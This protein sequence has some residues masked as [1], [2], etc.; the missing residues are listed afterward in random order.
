MEDK[1]M[2]E[3]KR[4]C[5]ILDRFGITTNYVHLI[6]CLLGR[7]GPIPAYFRHAINYCRRLVPG[8]APVRYG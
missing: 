8:K 2:Q 3:A 6:A 7:R 4:I 5:D 1:A